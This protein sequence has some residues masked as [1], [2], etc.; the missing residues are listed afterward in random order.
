[1]L[2]TT[3]P[4]LITRRQP[5]PIR[6]PPDQPP[7]RLLILEDPVH[8]RHLLPRTQ[9]PTT[10]VFIETSIPRWINPADA[11]LDLTVDSPLPVAPST[12]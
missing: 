12:A 4:S 11:I 1:M 7:D 8:N 10:I 2:I 6:E 9:H 5:P 3:R